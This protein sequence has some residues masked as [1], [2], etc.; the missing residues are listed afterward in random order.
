[1]SIYRGESCASLKPKKGFD[2]FWGK[3]GD[4]SASSPAKRYILYLASHEAC[5]ILDLISQEN[6]KRLVILIVE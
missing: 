2:L 4:Y 3:G 6:F 5:S 1:M